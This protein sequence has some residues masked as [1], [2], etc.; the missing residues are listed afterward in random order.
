MLNPNNPLTCHSRACGNPAKKNIRRSRQNSVVDSLREALLIVWIP[1]A[2]CPRK[3]V[4]G[5][6]MTHFFDYELSGLKSCVAPLL[7]LSLLSGTAFAA[8]KDDG[9]E[10]ARRFQQ[11]IRALEQE[12]AQLLQD[13][14]Q[15][16]G[17]VKETASQIDHAKRNADAATRKGSALDRELKAAEEEKAALTDK[18][19]KS[20]QKLA[21][22]QATLETTAATLRQTQELKAQL[23]ASLAQRNQEFAACS[24]K[25]DSLYKLGIAMGKQCEEKTILGGILTREPLT[26]LKRVE[27]EN[28]LEEYRDK[29][30]QSLM[31]Q[32]PEERLRLAREKAEAEK[33]AQDRL[34]RQQARKLKAEQEKAATV[35]TKEQRTF[36]RWARKAKDMFEGFEW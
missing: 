11:K 6:G 1:A 23:D 7:V 30:D 5:A 13:K 25:N 9:K 28:A 2:A 17:K 20:E 12:K 14:M 15:L 18:L 31:E 34:D 24:S 16:D 10:Q 33:E 22:T 3:M 29:L 21:E 27:E 32:T 8:N 26:Q 19:A 35:Q 4:S 36:T